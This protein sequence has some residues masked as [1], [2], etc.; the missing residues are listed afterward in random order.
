MSPAAGPTTGGNTVTINGTNF[1]SGAGVKFGTTA[2]ATVTFVSAMQLTAVAP[3]H[4]AG[5]IDVTVTTPGGTSA[6]VAGDHYAY[7]SPTV[8][9][10]APTSGMTGSTVTINGTGFVAGATVKFGTKP[11]GS[12]TFVS[13]T[14]IKAIVPN[15]AVTAK[16][17]VTTPAGTGTSVSNFTVTL[18][19][20]GFSPATGPTGTVVTI[21]GV[22]FNSSSTVK[23]NGATGSSVVHVSST[24]LKATVPSTATTGPISVTNTTAPSGTVQSAVNY[25]KT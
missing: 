8:T 14:Q 3:V 12:V 13:G 22:G 11:T 23:F 7:G 24:Q 9:S 25:T 10:F 4:A 15:G 1:T 18:S 19:I 20:T 16:I 2:S 6:L 5:T 21:N 17:S